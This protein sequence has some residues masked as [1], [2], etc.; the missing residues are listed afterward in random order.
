MKSLIFLLI[1]SSIFSNLS[2]SDL[3]TKFQQFIK[4]YNK[5]YDSIEEYLQRFNIFK[6]HLSSLQNKNVN[7]PLH[8]TIGITKFSDLTDEEFRK[9]YLGLKVNKSNFVNL[10]KVTLKK[11]IKLPESFD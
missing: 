2:D 3:F 6:A 4:K 11:D 8:H 9:K 5:H 7:E 1:I 10:K